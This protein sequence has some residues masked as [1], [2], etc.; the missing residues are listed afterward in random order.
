MLRTRLKK[1]C[2]FGK[3]VINIMCCIKIMK[4]NENIQPPEYAAAPP[5]IPEF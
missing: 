2:Y 1:S 3:H 5:E 4:N